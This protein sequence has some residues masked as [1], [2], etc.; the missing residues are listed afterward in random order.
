MCENVGVS[1]NKCE[2]YMKETFVYKEHKQKHMLWVRKEKGKGDREKEEGGGKRRGEGEMKIYNM[3]TNA[4]VI[5]EW[6]GAG[7]G[8]E[9]ENKIYC[10]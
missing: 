8:E 10:T 2:F 7:A 6:E 5:G 9:K 3:K 1:R 4:L